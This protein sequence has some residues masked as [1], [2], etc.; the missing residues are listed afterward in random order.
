MGLGVNSMRKNTESESA[1]EKNRA[2]FKSFIATRGGIGL[3]QISIAG[4][5]ISLL[6]LPIT[7]NVAI[8]GY[9][10]NPLESKVNIFI[11]C[12]A[13]FMLLTFL[14]VNLSAIRKILFQH[15]GLLGVWGFVQSILLTIILMFMFYMI[16]QWDK[17]NEIW[18]ES[19]FSII[20]ITLFSLGYI[21]CLIYN[22]YWLKKQL[23]IGFSIE[24]TTANYFAHSKVYES[25]SLWIIFGSSMIGAFL[26]GNL[27]KVFG[28]VFGLFLGAVFS[29]LTIELGYSAYLL[30]KNKDYW[31][32]YSNEP[33]RVWKKIIE[34][35]LKST[36]TYVVL[37][38]LLIFA[39][40]KI[41]DMYDVPTVWNIIFSY[42][43][44]VLLI[45]LLLILIWWTIKKL[46][47]W[48]KKMKLKTRQFSLNNVIGFSAT[49][50]S[51][52]DRFDQVAE[53]GTKFKELLIQI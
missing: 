34:L 22:F 18:Y 5:I 41:E 37:I 36:S 33:K 23:V 3:L 14:S 25:K 38:M 29:R 52:N 40:A 50:D 16:T 45:S 39:I 53:M 11:I 42:L 44:L 13:I 21:G 6:C 49:L 48:E 43:T 47:C 46:K 31:I 51:D 8:L 7:W 20:I 4:L 1:D 17:P 19:N 15:Q 10:V 30:N 27:A 32:T 28:V 24:R 2:Y 9:G 35:R 12:I 26:T